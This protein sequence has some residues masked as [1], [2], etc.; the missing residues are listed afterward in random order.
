MLAVMYPDLNR[1][2]FGPDFKRQLSRSYNKDGSFIIA[3]DL[4]V[5]ITI[6]S[7]G[8]SKLY[9]KIDGIW[10][11]GH[12]SYRPYKRILFVSVFEYQSSINFSYEKLIENETSQTIKN[13]LPFNYFF[14]NLAGFPDVTKEITIVLAELC[15]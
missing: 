10:Y 12:S 7:N 3:E 14:T 8:Y 2:L 6:F 1:A 11:E 15:K 13:L 5:D 4:P 9:S